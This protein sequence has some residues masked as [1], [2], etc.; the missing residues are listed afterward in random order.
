MTAPAALTRDGLVS[1]LLP[2]DEYLRRVATLLGADHALRTVLDRFA[3]IEPHVQ[4]DARPAL[5]SALDAALDRASLV[6]RTC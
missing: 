4:E 6:A 3:A 5:F 2:P 1:E